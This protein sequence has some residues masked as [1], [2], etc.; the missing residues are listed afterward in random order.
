MICFR[1]A[2]YGTPLRVVPASQPARYNRARDTEP[3][4]YLALHP[5]GPL[6]ELMRNHDLRT[7]AQIRATRTRTWAL[8]AAEVDDLPEITFDTAR[9]YGIGP[10]D[11]VADDRTACQ[12]LASRLRGE[13]RGVVVPSASLPG[14]R[15]AVLFGP[16]VASP[17]L[18]APV[19]ALD[20]PAGIT[21]ESGRAV[22][23]L[24]EIVRF[25]GQ[26]HAELDAWLSGADFRF[27]EP[28][29]APA[30]S[31]RNY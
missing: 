28:D 16:R 14:T 27:A 24:L 29:W 5:L 10:A 25:T 7:E 6:A 15:N 1:S 18:T 31:A 23:G 30:A 12:D 26:A 13:L 17:Y 11:L 4:Q 3:T 20:L 22:T 2:D 9:D 21:A 8:Q 19:S